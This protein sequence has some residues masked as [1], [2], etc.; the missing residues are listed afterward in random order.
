MEMTEMIFDR[1]L[2]K[3]DVVHIHN[4]ILLNH[5][6]KRNAAICDNVDGYWDYH[7]E[8]NKSDRKS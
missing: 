2:N 7:A 8:Q 4:G 6:K 3:E 1:W 5:K